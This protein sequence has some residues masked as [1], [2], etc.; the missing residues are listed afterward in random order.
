MFSLHIDTARTWRGGQNQALLTVMGLRGIGHRAALVA[1]A[2]GELRRR[3]G[4]GLDLI[5]I[6]TRNEMDLSAAWKLGRVLRT[7]RPEIIH[8]HDPHGVAMASLAISL[9]PA[10]PAPL[11]VASRRVDFPLKTHAFSRWKYRQVDLF[12]CAS[13]AI[14]RI[15]AGHGVEPDRLVTV[16][17]GIDLAHVDAAPTADLH[18]QFWLPHGVPIV[19]NIGAL[20]PHKGQRHLVDAVPLVLRDVPDAHFVI[21]GEG[22]LRPDL[23]AQIRHLRLEKRI[24]LTGFRPDVLSL[25]KAFDVFVMAS[26]TEG[27]GTSVLDAMACRRAVV[28]TRAGGI[29][30]V[31]DEGRTGFV[32][33]THDAPAIAGAV[34]RLLKDPGLRTRL[35]EAGRRRVE[36]EFTAERMVRATLAAYE[37]L[38]GRRAAAGTPRSP[39]R[40]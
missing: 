24:L 26:L 33:P 36:R 23:E 22:E 17:E 11:L 21:A 3:A 19:G 12:L 1:H 40:G 28:G 25:L 6:S 10:L 31:V 18:A 27:L 39:G 35:G 14:R 34:V 30:E 8:A 13:D 9:N 15:L 4:E 20:V 37:A 38:A 32:V 5:P 16:H 2:D 29:P 7:E